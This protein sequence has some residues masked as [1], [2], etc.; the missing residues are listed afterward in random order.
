MLKVSGNAVGQISF[1]VGPDKFIGIKL[2]GISREVKGLDSR[3]ASKESFD[4]LGSVERASVPEK[5]ERT[6]EVTAKVSEE[7][8]DLFSPD[9]LVGVKTSVES[10]AFS[11]G[12]DRDGG[13][14]RDFSPASGDHE[15][16]CFAFNRPGSLE[17]GNER[18]SALIQEYQAGSKPIGLFLYA[19]KRDTSNNEWLV[20]DVLWPF[21][22]ASGNSSPS[23]PSD[24]KDLRCSS[25]LENSSERLDRYASRSKDPSNSQLPMGL[26]P[27]YAPRFFSAR[28]REAEAGPDA[29][30]DLIPPALSS[31]RLDANALRSLEMRPLPRLRRGTDGLVLKAGRPDADVFPVLGIAMRSHSALQGYPCI[32]D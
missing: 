27:K 7:L 25:G 28:L 29:A 18:E 32:I 30:W 22:A 1:E 16:W 15:R 31:G 24:S 12:R 13:D 2:R 4:E 6:F 19:A 23:R 21:S 11:L 8:P 3:I 10:K 26:S 9:V 17:I 5:D 14:G 20:R